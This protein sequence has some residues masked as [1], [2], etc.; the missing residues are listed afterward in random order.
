MFDFTII[1]KMTT[2]LFIGWEETEAKYSNMPKRTH[3]IAR[4]CMTM[5]YGIFCA[6]KIRLLE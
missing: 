6:Y 3:F 2:K 4:V 1:S 5:N